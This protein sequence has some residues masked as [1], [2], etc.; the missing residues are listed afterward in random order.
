MRKLILCLLSIAATYVA[1]APSKCI[2]EKARM[3]PEGLRTSATVILTGKIAQ[4]YSVVTTS[5]DK[6]VTN[7]V[8]EVQVERVEKGKYTAPLAYARFYRVRDVGKGPFPPGDHGH[9]PTPKIGEAVRVFVTA[10]RDG[11]FDVLLPNGFESREGSVK[12]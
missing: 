10:G 1:I 3:F 5:K 12:K 11:G 8:A 4:I 6:E 7:F 9:N 2:A